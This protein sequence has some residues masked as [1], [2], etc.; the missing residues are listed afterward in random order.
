MRV[1][2]VIVWEVDAVDVDAASEM[3][4]GEFRGPRDGG[5]LMEWFE[6][7]RIG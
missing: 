2:Q 3:V 1:R 6:I 4:M 5:P 7:E